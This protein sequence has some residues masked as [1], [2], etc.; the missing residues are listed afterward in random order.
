MNGLSFTPQEQ[1]RSI[2]KIIPDYRQDYSPDFRQAIADSWPE[3]LDD[4]AAR[5]DWGW[6][7]EFDIDRITKDMVKNLSQ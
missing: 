5:N 1:A 3:S 2:Q 4:S 6:R 7:P